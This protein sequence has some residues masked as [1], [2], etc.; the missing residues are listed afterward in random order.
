MD[1]FLGFFAGELTAVIIFYFIFRRQ[2]SKE[3]PTYFEGTRPSTPPP[4]GHARPL[5]PPDPEDAPPPPP[6]KN[7]G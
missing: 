2:E 7:H 6:R 3:I 5:I 4:F 1:F